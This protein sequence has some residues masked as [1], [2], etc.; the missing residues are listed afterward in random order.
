[1]KNLK[2]LLPILFLLASGIGAFSQEVQIVCGEYTYHAP[3]G[4]PRATAMRIAQERARMQALADAF[5]TTDTQTDSLTTDNGQE[6]ENRSSSV[7]TTV[8]TNAEWL[9]NERKPSY[10]FDTNRKDGTLTVTCR[11]C[12]KA[13]RKVDS[14][15]KVSSGASDDTIP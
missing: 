8:R 7:L 15:C 9:G 14:P 2:H 10:T 1:M 4:M 12:G 13:R 5:G 3:K 11:L 6:Q